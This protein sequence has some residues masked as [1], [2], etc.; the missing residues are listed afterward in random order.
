VH[1]KLYQGNNLAQ[2][3]FLDYLQ[4]VTLHLARSYQ[5]EGLSWDVE[6]DEVFLGVDQAIPCGLIVNELVSNAMKHAFVGRDHGTLLV[7]L[8]NLTD[9]KATL[10]VQDDGVGFPADKDFRAASSMGMVLIMALVE[11]LSARIS[12]DRAGGTMFT[13]EFQPHP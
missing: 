4:S 5:R 3:N 2:V 1:E 9:G 13:L 10:R 8:R 11:Q 12:L 7:S 6:G